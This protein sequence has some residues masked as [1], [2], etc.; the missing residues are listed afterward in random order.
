MFAVLLGT[1]FAGQ[2]AGT[3]MV[4]MSLLLPPSTTR[5]HKPGSAV[6]SLAATT[7]PVV[8]PIVERQFKVILLL[9]NLADARNPYLPQ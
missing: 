1:R 4:G 8:P 7:H 5:M 9:Q 3:A 2:R 6:A